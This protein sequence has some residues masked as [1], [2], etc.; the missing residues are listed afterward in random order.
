MCAT[1]RPSIR[2]RGLKIEGGDSPSGSR[3]TPQECPHLMKRMKTY[4][5]KHNTVINLKGGIKSAPTKDK[6]VEDGVEGTDKP[7]EDSKRKLKMY[8]NPLKIQREGL[9]ML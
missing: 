6:V 3:P 9:K 8:A 1:T 7:F 5:D 4:S 2:P